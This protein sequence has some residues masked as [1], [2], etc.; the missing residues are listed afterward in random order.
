MKKIFRR[1][2]FFLIL[3]IFYGFF[4][5]PKLLIV[6]T[7]EIKLTQNYQN[8]LNIVIFADT[9]YDKNT[10][11]DEILD[12]VVKIN[13]LNPDIVVFLGDLIDNYNESPPDISLIE[14]GFRGIKTPYKY[15]IIGNHDYGGGAEQV[16][17]D[18]LDNSDFTLL[19][20]QVKVLN[21]FN[22]QL[23]GL[24][25]MLMGEPDLSIITEREGFSNIILTHEGDIADDIEPNFGVLLSG[26]SHGGQINLPFIRDYVS[27]LGAENYIKGL[28]KLNENDYVFTTSGIGTTKIDFRLFNIP[29]IVDLTLK[30]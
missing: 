23:I 18:I 11:Y 2:T 29:E 13:A 7:Q 1:C 25:E 10:T 3:L 5:E 15:A 27:P 21:E 14:K 30:Y 8:E 17:K 26:H 22:I 20:N 28:Y 6:T 19:V 24:D 12:L 16:Y 4:I 9:H